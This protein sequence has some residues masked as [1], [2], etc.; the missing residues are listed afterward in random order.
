[1]L[2]ARHKNEIENADEPRESSINDEVTAALLGRSWRSSTNGENNPHE[3]TARISLLKA[4]AK[5]YRI[6]SLKF[7]AAAMLNN[8]DSS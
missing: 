7:L 8:G 3:V 4:A 2:V 1:M 6:A 5:K